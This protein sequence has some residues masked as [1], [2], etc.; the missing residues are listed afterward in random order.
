MRKNHWH[1][2]IPSE[3]A[4]DQRILQSDWLRA[5]PAVNQ[6]HISQNFLNF[7]KI[8]KFFPNRRLLRED[9]EQYQFSFKKILIKN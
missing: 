3:D 9:R 1:P 2:V 5:V 4:T 7:S 8:P 6:G